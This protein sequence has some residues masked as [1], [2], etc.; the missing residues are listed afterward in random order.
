[1][2]QSRALKYSPGIEMALPLVFFSNETL[3]YAALLILC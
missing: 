3:G 2:K 1:M